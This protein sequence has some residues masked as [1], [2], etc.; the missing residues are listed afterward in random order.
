M[1]AVVE[2]T[3]LCSNI[4]KKAFIQPKH[5][6][7]CDLETDHKPSSLPLPPATLRNIH[8]HMPFEEQ[9]G[10]HIRSGNIFK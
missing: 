7:S 8:T 1:A 2:Q 6:Q 4:L 9:T 5:Q 10:N 3:L